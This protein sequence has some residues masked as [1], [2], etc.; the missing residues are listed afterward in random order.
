MKKGVLIMVLIL[1]TCALFASGGKEEAQSTEDVPFA[2]REVTLQLV[3]EGNAEQQE[4][5]QDLKK[6]FN[7]EYP[8]IK[9]NDIWLPMGEGGW[10]AYFTKIKTMVASGNS[11]DVVRVAVE[12]FLVLHES[13]LALPLNSYVEDYPQY[14][15]NYEDIHPRLQEA[16]VIDGNIYGFGWDWNNIVTHINL[17]MLEEAGLPFP[18]ADWGKDEFL[19]Y[20]KALTGMKDGQ[21]TYGVYIPNIYFSIE[22]WLYNFGAA[23]LSDDMTRGALSTP[24]SIEAFTFMHDLVYKHKVA[25]VPA[26]GDQFIPFMTNRQV[27]MTFGGRWPVPSYVDAGLNFDIQYVPSFRTN[28]VIFGVGMFP[29]M[30]SS[31]YPE[32][33]YVL[34]SWLS[35]RHSQNTYLNSF[36]IPSRISV[37]DEVLPVN[38]PENSTLYRLSAD[39]A[40][41]VQSP[42]KY[43]EVQQVVDRM[44]NRMMSDPNA[45]VKAILAS[46]DDELNE[47]LAR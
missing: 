2:S 25:P 28:E 10:G 11:P 39:T 34:S 22:S 19:Q 40:R 30:T 8:N 35:G 29:V 17:D 26:P 20:A 43:P 12:G 1:S 46:A 3:M 6:D 5:M 7:K 23:V 38:P 31:K 33:A 21:M 16:C 15:E 44:F 41:V 32:E 45:D 4:W 36:S 18:D 24:E 9:I 14:V 37:M 47:V 13:D 27:A 42:S